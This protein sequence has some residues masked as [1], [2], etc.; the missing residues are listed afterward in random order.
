LGHALEVDAPALPSRP[1]PLAFA[2][3]VPTTPGLQWTRTVSREA[4]SSPIS[5]IARSSEAAR[6]RPLGWSEIANG[7]WSLLPVGR[8]WPPSLVSW[9]GRWKRAHHRP[10]K[11]SCEVSVCFAPTLHKPVD[12]IADRKDWKSCAHDRPW[13]TAISPTVYRW[14]RRWVR[15]WRELRVCRHSEYGQYGNRNQR[16]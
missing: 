2:G 7:N 15:S 1:E 10:I 12:T 16:S 3:G 11:A 4:V 9:A 8:P 5:R 13:R 6:P 14:G